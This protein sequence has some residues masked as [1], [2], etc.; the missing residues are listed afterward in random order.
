M[1]QKCSITQNTTQAENVDIDHITVD[2]DIQQRAEGLDATVVS[3]YRTLLDGSPDWPFPP[4]VAFQ[5]DDGTL[6]LA[7]GFHRIKAASDTGR[8]TIPVDIRLGC[9]RDAL[10]YAVGANAAH[11]LRRKNEDK[12]R[13]VLTLL[14]DAQWGA[15]TDRQIAEAA[16]VSH[17]FVG[18]IR[19]EDEST[20]PKK[21]LVTF[22]TGQKLTSS[23]Q[24]A[25]TTE[26]SS[27]PTPQT[28]TGRD[29]K[30][31]PTKRTS[32]DI[33]PEPQAA[34]DQLRDRAAKGPTLQPEP[35]PPTTRRTPGEKSPAVVAQQAM[36]DAG[37]AL[38]EVDRLR[39][40]IATHHEAAP[41]LL[42]AAKAVLAWLGPI[43]EGAANG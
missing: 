35:E 42:A 40:V 16:R 39:T 4:V 11:G 20:N 22:P 23:D 8:R 9:R 24:P 10:L 34:I 12:R 37:A 18:K 33:P 15:L 13:A 6:V 14:Q 19:R 5:A 21:K 29:G 41:Q 25:A 27:T 26:P 43:V 7:D 38:R 28:R 3:E 36:L 31:Y 2:A 30:A 17:P 1:H 32:T